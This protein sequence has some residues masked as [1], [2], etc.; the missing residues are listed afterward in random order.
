MDH[1]FKLTPWKQI[2]KKS[3]SARFLLTEIREKYAIAHIYSNKK[4][5]PYSGTQ[6]FCKITVPQLQYYYTDK[7]IKKCMAKLEKCEKIINNHN[8]FTRKIDA[9]RYCEQ[10][11][12]NHGF[13][14]LQDKHINFF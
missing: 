8:F 3:H 13:Y 2:N 6:W 7:D 1:F 10:I 11:L 4:A 5:K 9:V 12:K 14:L